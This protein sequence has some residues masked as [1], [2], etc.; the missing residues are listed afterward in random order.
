MGRFINSLK[1]KVITKSKEWN[2]EQTDKLLFTIRDL[3]YKPR[4]KKYS[5]FD[6]FVIIDQDDV[7]Y[8]EFAEK[9]KNTT[10]GQAEIYNNNETVKYMAPNGMIAYISSKDSGQ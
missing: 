1:N 6:L 4:F 9:L 8:E 2:Q 5:G 10:G 3:G 7:D